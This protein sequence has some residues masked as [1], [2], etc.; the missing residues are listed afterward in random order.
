MSTPEKPDSAHNSRAHTLNPPGHSHWHFLIL[1]CLGF[2]VSLLTDT[3]WN[4]VSPAV[5]TPLGGLNLA[6]GVAIR[7][8]NQGTREILE[9]ELVTF[10][11]SHKATVLCL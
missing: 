11:I 6:Y 2:N 7:N 4:T 3:A 9:L 5:V 8:G 10:G 1:S